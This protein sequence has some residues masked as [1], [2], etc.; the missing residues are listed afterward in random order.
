MT[1]ASQ[2]TRNTRPVPPMAS[3]HFWFIA[4]TIH[5]AVDANRYPLGGDDPERHK[6]LVAVAE[7]FARR[8]RQSN[9][10]FRAD[11]FLA[12]CGVTE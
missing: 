9:G 2:K 3:R 7:L 12:A 4:D 1:T 10:Q 5:E 8:L 6:A 11:Q